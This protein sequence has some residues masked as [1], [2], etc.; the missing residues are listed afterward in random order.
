MAQK[1]FLYLRGLR[2]V[3]FTVFAVADGQKKYWDA[4]YRKE[5]P[6][7][8]GQQ[9]KR[10]LLEA[11]MAEIGQ[12]MAPVEFRYKLDKADKKTAKAK[13]DIALQTLDPTYPDQ[14]IGGWMRATGEGKEKE[15]DN[16]IK[17]RSPLS[18]SALR[19]LHPLLAGM[20]ND[21][22]MTF[23]RR[24]Q[25]TT[26]VR[27]LDAAGN[28][29]TEDE[30]VEFISNSDKPLRP[31]KYLG[32]KNPR[33]SGLFVYDVAIDLRRLFAVSLDRNDPE[34]KKGLADELRIKGWNESQNAFGPCLVCPADQR[35]EIIPALAHA[36]INWDITSNQARTYHPRE[37]LAV[38]ISQNAN[39]IVNAIR[40]DLDDSGENS[41]AHAIP[42]VDEEAGAKVFV[43]PV[44]S[45]KGLG[46]QG[47][48]TA[49][50]DA[51]TY[52]KTVL[53]AFPYVS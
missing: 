3:D 9:V 24:G 20:V 14:L 19:P 46:V 13:E 1:P 27:L 44:A 21:A 4:L 51:E 6:F 11:M 2:N 28:E 23:D 31:F 17:R 22:A 29:M 7:A 5:V 16:V 43:A 18:I 8:S 36:L 34:L 49:L 41:K 47:N 12:G 10:S 38:A 26:K 50:D 39:Q 48:S 45:G 25:S 15:D 30:M 42:R 40:A 53:A 52:I 35:K 32:D 33:A 37:V